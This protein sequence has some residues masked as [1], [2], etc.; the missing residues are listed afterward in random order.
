[1]KAKQRN[2]DMSS[3]RTVSASEPLD[4]SAYINK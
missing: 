2:S 4:Q 3:W 1:V